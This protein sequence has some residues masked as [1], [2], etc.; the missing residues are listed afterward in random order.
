VIRE[1]N[2]GVGIYAGPGGLVEGVAIRNLLTETRLTAGAWWGKG[3]PLFLAS[4]A[5]GGT[6]RDVSATSMDCRAEQGIVLYAPGAGTIR[7]ITLSGARLR[8][9]EGAMGR[10]LGGTIDPRPDPIVRSPTRPLIA[11]GVRGLTLRGLDVAW[12]NGIP[13]YA[14][15]GIELEGCAGVRIDGYVEH[16]T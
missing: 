1:S 15:S 12:P 4:M 14:A 3:E 10:H 7:E 16:E 11:H 8:M 2:R 9:T 5:E 13:S 6:I